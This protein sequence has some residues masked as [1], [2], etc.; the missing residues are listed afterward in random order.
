M[1]I[2]TNP[3][4]PGI[5]WPGMCFI[6]SVDANKRGFVSES[7]RKWSDHNA[8]RL[9]AALA[10]YAIL[11][12][13][14][15]LV[16][17]VALCGFLFGQDAVRGQIFWQVRDV[18]GDQ[19]ASAVQAILKSADR[20]AS[21]IWATIV[22]FLTLLIGASGVFLELRGTLNLYGMHRLPKAFGF[23]GLLRERFFSL[24]W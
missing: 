10:F 8:P 3:K 5:V 4:S 11:S 9:G 15:A 16:L 2:E 24:Q 1:Q 18:I 21:G 6:A 22:G 23:S 20:P 19:A 12:L 14:P 17:I 13:A 7:C